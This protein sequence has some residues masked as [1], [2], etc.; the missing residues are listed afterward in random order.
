MLGQVHSAKKTLV[1]HINLSSSFTCT[2]FHQLHLFAIYFLESGHFVVQAFMN[3]EE[4]HHSQSDILPL[5]NW[6]ILFLFSNIDGL[7][8]ECWR[9]YLK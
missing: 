9:N 4:H 3:W 8:L 1:K 7:L 5:L 2:T 6:F